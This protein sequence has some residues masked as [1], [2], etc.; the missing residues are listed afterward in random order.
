M[1]V[2][3]GGFVVVL[4][5]RIL[6]FQT[7][8]QRQRVAQ[9]LPTSKK[10]KT[11]MGEQV[12]PAQRRGSSRTTSTMQKRCIEQRKGRVTLRVFDC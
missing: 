1:V 8:G 11:T 7:A 3:H 12:E 9:T 4:V 6:G 5:V 2:K 10:C